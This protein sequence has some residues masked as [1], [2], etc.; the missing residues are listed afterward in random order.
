MNKIKT[1]IFGQRFKNYYRI[2]IRSVS[3]FFRFLKWYF[4]EKRLP[5]RLGEAAVY[6]FCVMVDLCKARFTRTD[7]D[8]AG[9]DQPFLFRLAASLVKLALAF[10]TRFF[11]ILIFTHIRKNTRFFARFGETAE[12][13]LKRFGGFNVNAYRSETITSLNFQSK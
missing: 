7:L 10:F 6:V 1:D 9:F 5:F 11:K 4:N 2:Y 13:F 3:I 12:G 8:D